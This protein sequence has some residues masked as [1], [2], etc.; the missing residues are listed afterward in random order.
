MRASAA[1]R[2]PT[3]LCSSPERE[4]M[5]TSYSG[6]S[7]DIEVSSGQLGVAARGGGSGW[8]L[9]VAARGGGSRRPLSARLL[10]RGVRGGGLAHP[11]ALLVSA[12]ARL[13]ALAVAG[14]VALQHRL[15]FAPVDRPEAEMPGRLVPA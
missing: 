11:A 10:F 4:R 1:C 14:P 13:H 15:E 2:L 12:P 6:Q 7:F 3:C 8:R 5:K 9:G